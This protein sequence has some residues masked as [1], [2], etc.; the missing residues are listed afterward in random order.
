MQEYLMR[1]FGIDENTSATIVITLLIAALGIAI[2]LVYQFSSK[3]IKRWQRRRIF[4]ISVKRY[5][6]QISKQAI[7]Y[8]Q[9]ADKFT[10]ENQ[11]GFG[12]TRTDLFPSQVLS[13]LGY[14]ETYEACFSGI[15]N[16][17]KC[18]NKL[19]LKAFNKIWECVHS[20][21]YLHNKSFDGMD[22]FI[23]QYNTTN[24]ARNVALTAHQKYWEPI[25]LATD[26]ETVERNIGTY[27][28]GCDRVHVEWQNTEKRTRPDIVQRKLVLPLRI[29]NRKYKAQEIAQVMNYN[30]LT[31]SAEYENQRTLLRG[32]K[33]QFK[34]YACTFRYWGRVTSKSSKILKCFG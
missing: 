25:I 34:I 5:S 30:L 4:F 16:T 8:S 2:N 14:K 17:L 3:L 13:D 11:E 27:L 23:E 9:T 28:Q 29:H 26:G 19:R 21:D 20:T 31:A 15:E 12:F 1:E 33:R 7:G 10:F 18:K 24:T 32:N 6:H 22:K